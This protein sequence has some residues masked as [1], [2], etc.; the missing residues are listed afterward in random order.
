MADSKGTDLIVNVPRGGQV[1]RTF[2]LTPS[3]P[4]SGKAGDWPWVDVTAP[5]TL[6]ANVRAKFSVDSSEMEQNFERAVLVIN[7]QQNSSETGYWRFALDGVAIT[8]DSGD[9]HRNIEFE[10]VDGGKT[11]I[12]HIQVIGLTEEYVQFGFV[13]SYTDAVSGEVTI[14]Q[15]VDPGVG[16]GRP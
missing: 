12:V 7:I 11:L 4:V 15:S 16:G 6:L 5:A 1:I 3:L 14:Y 10:V 13:A 9:D 8:P 2:N